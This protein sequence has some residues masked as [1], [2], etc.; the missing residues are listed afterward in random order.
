MPAGTSPVFVATP[1]SYEVRIATANA[2]RDGTGTLGTLATGVANGS[3]VQAIRV[4]ADG[5]TTA[6]VVRIF[7]TADT[8]TTKRLLKELLIPAVTPSTTIEAFSI[9][10]APT[11][12]IILNGASY[13]LYASTNNAEGFVVLAVGGDY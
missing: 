1:K 8:G 12:P 3:V 9:E 6:G 7:L 4:Q 2:G 5:T 10:W 11:E 13:V